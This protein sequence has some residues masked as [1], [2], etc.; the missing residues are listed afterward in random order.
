M[1]RDHGNPPETMAPLLDRIRQHYDPDAYPKTETPA[2]PATGR[3]KSFAQLRTQMSGRTAMLLG[4]RLRSLRFNLFYLTQGALR[5]LEL[6]DA[7]ERT[8]DEVRSLN[9]QVF[10]FENYPINDRLAVVAALPQTPEGEEEGPDWTAW[11][12]DH[13][14][15]HIGVHRPQD[16]DPKEDPVSERLN[17][18]IAAMA[19]AALPHLPSYLECARRLKEDEPRKALSLAAVCAAY[20]K[21]RLLANRIG[22]RTDFDPDPDQAAS[23]LTGASLSFTKDL[24]FIKSLPELREERPAGGTEK[25]R[26]IIS[27]NLWHDRETLRTAPPF[28]RHSNM[29]VD[30]IW[31]SPETGAAEISNAERHLIRAAAPPHPMM[32][33][34]PIWV[35]DPAAAAIAFK[36]HTTP[37]HAREFLS[38]QTDDPTPPGNL[39]RCPMASECRTWCGR[40]Q[41]QG[42]LPFPLTFDGRYDSCA[43]HQFLQVHRNNAPEF[44]EEAAKRMA[45]E[46]HERKTKIAKHMAKTQRQEEEE[47]QGPQEGETPRET[48]VTGSGSSKEEPPPRAET[49]AK[50]LQAAMF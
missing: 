23:E 44:R 6:L 9:Y 24:G 5:T 20:S 11:W 49:Q 13:R 26:T 7:P 47:S 50:S 4:E 22:V 39:D 10:H 16:H 28:G 38:G 8:K 3:P 43:Y 18:L 46:E 42:D 30:D 48:R 45:Q 31:E 35:Q 1:N 37:K 12:L 19:R 27:A 40:L 25:V 41:E 36:N 15:E 2:K 34:S 14:D 33:D 17:V 32:D 21:T 29:N